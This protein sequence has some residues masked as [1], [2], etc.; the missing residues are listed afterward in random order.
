MKWF[1][2]QEPENSVY[3]SLAAVSRAFE[4]VLPTLPTACAS[5]KCCADLT[6]QPPS[7]GVNLRSGPR[8]QLAL[9]PLHPPSLPAARDR[10]SRAA[11]AARAGLSW[12]RCKPRSASPARPPIPKIRD[13]APNNF[14]IEPRCGRC[15]PAH[16]AR[17]RVA[18][19]I[20]VARLRLANFKGFLG[21]PILSSRVCR[22][23]SSSGSSWPEICR[24]RGF[25]FKSPKT[26]S[27][28]AL[29]SEP[30]FVQTGASLG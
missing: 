12:W 25:V 30:S 2:L 26:Q 1:R 17:L 3:Q 18:E 5:S 20:L 13:S 14:T 15:S 11:D 4:R 22:R 8:L 7:V 28:R 10:A 21:L 24:A 16:D 6:D 23:C 9:H 27:I 29:P 19:V